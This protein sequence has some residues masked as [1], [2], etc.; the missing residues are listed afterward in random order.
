MAQL[1]APYRQVLQEL[2][3]ILS[4]EWTASEGAR[5]VG[6]DGLLQLKTTA[7]KHSLWVQ[8]HRSHLSHLFLDHLITQL[9]RSQ[10]PLLVL[11]P[12]V[13]AGAA[14]KMANA[15]INYLDQRGNCRIALGGLFLQ[16]EGKT[17]AQ[18]PAAQKWLRSPAYQ[19]LFVFLADPSLLNEPLREIATWAGVSRQPILAMKHRLL[20]ERYA[21]VSSSR[22]RW[23]PDRWPEALALWLHGYE[24]T[25]RPSLL[26][27]SYRTR[28]ADPSALEGKIARTLPR[29]EYRWGGSAAGFRLSPHYRG[30]RTVVHV[31]SLPANLPKRLEA[32]SDPAGN[33]LVMKAPGRIHW[34]RQHDT[35]H[36]LLVYSEMLSEGNERAREAARLLYDSHVAPLSKL[37]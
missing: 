33:L 4:F 34:E 31:E 25:V 35:V 26:I 2:P 6:I 29:A 9:R 5:D 24:T 16:I 18:T 23:N 3:G 13:G 37:P 12:Y 11:A 36:P 1:D 21:F 17:A 7:G 15:D 27:G 20:D 10:H 22:T 8:Q 14:A 28:E 30:Q 32:L 19:A